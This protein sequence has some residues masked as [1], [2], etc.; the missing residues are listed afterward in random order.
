MARRA[1]KLVGALWVMGMLVIA[2]SAWAQ[3]DLKPE[4]FI[5][6]NFK[7][8]SGAILEEMKVEYAT[9]GT[10]T[11][12]SSGNITNAVFF[13]HGYSGNYSQIKL[14]KDVVG[15]GLP[16]DTNKYFIVCPSALGSPGS[17]SPSVSGLGPKFPKYGVADMISAQYLL[18]T[19]HFKIKHLLGV[20]GASMG[21]MQT[22]QW[23]TQ[24]P[25]FMDWAIPIAMGHEFKGRNVGIFGVMSHAI[26]SDPAYM[27]GNYK[28]QPQ[29][30]MEQAFMGVYLWYFTPTFFKVNY[31]TNEE[32]LKG[33][34][35]VGLGSST[36]D[37][38]D[39]LWRN[40]AMTDYNLTDELPKVKAKTLV[41]GVNTDELF[42]PEAEFQV[43]AKLIPGAKLFAY[44]SV[45]GHLGCAVDIKK[46]GESIASFLK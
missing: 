4:Y 16:F 39:I 5:A 1:F 34:K 15:P 35:D 29:K 17:S 8:K 44:D 13:C 3:F 38:N 20:A 40:D 28:S 11:K 23:I 12:D 30:G 33:L 10:P 2:S 43:T 31:K 42:P 18:A 27:D 45:A 26:R 22:L 32:L 36:M 14:M 46:A 24:Y 37:A 9:L 25:D 41:I 7:L 6:K 19:E 21:G